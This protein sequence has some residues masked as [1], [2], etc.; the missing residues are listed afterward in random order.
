MTQKNCFIALIILHR[1]YHSFI[2]QLLLLSKQVF[3]T[4]SHSF[5]ADVWCACI[6]YMFLHCFCS[7]YSKYACCLVLSSRLSIACLVFILFAALSWLH[8][9]GENFV[10]TWWKDIY[11]STWLQLLWTFHCSGTGVFETTTF[12]YSRTQF[13]ASHSLSSGVLRLKLWHSPFDSLDA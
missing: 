8:S 2:I 5:C 6:V 9:V 13:R 4:L 10:H 1:I 3:C 7:Q 11:L 12:S